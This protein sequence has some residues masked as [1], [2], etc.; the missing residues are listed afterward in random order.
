MAYINRVL[1]LALEIEKKSLKQVPLLALSVFIL[2][3]IGAIFSTCD[4]ATFGT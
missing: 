1:F 2:T 3:A 4:G